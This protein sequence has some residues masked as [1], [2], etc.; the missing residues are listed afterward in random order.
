MRPDFNPRTWLMHTR[1]N[2]LLKK[3]LTNDQP[4]R[5]I[6]KLAGVGVS[7]NLTDSN[8]ASKLPATVNCIHVHT[9]QNNIALF[10]VLSS[11]PAKTR[12]CLA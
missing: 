1:L 11:E 9:S 2:Q 5:Q 12:Y 10:P 7:T 8:A 3:V 6:N 4:P